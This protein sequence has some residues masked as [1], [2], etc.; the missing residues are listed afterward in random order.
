MSNIIFDDIWTNSGS[1]SN[2]ILEDLEDVAG[3]P[4]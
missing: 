2:G 4:Y 3:A 1:F